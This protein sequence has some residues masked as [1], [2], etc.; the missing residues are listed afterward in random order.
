M[1]TDKNIQNPESN[2]LS[3]D[4]LTNVSGGAGVEG[5]SAGVITAGPSTSKSTQTLVTT[6]L[7]KITGKKDS[8][9]DKGKT[10]RC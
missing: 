4:E 3:D 1:S 8:S 5:A 7:E 10:S 2:A 6:L 9:K